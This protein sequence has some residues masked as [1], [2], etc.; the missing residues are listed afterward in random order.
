MGDIKLFKIKDEVEEIE[1]TSMQLEK[2]LQN[3]IEENMEVFLGVKFLA[4]EY[5]TGKV[6][7]GRIDSLGIDEN[8][9]PVII[10]YKRSINENVINQGLYY[11][12]WLLDHKAEFKLLVMDKLGVKYCENIEWSSPRLI[13]IANDFTKYDIHAVKQINRNID[14]I[15]YKN[16]K[17]ELLLLEMVHTN[18]VSDDYKPIE[19]IDNPI[20]Y[21]YKTVE[22]YLEDANNKLKNRYYI[23]KDFIMSLGDDVQ[24]KKLKNYFGFKRIKNFACIEIHPK[25]DLVLVYTKANLQEIEFEKGFTRDVTNIGHF[26]TGNLEIRFT[27]MKQLD[28]VQK[29]IL[30]SYEMN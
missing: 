24:E 16:Y 19:N 25:S 6:H 5:S 14:L 3:I 12:D 20:K 27:D 21:K 28:E 17:E 26:G 23:L 10:E 15:K 4:T 11:L 1:G 18:T 2:H 7:N 29:Y 30:K 8:N 9:C 22:D 13:C